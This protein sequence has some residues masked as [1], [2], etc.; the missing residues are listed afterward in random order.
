M[1][2]QANLHDQHIG[3][4]HSPL[5]VLSVNKLQLDI[6]SVHCI[7][8]HLDQILTMNQ[9]PICLLRLV[10]HKLA[11]ILQSQVCCIQRIPAGIRLTLQTTSRIQRLTLPIAKARGF[12]TE[13]LFL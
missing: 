13:S 3:L 8:C 10:A 11:C 4:C 12:F 9:S 6:G 2:C 1:I 5:I 7:L